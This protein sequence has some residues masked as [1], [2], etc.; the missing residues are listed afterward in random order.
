[1]CKYGSLLHFWKWTMGIILLCKIGS[2]LLHFDTM[3]IGKNVLSILCVK[4]LNEGV[5]M[6]SEIMSYFELNN[7]KYTFELCKV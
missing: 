7:W 4:Y 2:D 6:G 5:L 3:E 1:M